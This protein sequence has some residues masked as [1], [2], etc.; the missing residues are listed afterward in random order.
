MGLFKSV[1]GF[2]EEKINLS[3]VETVTGEIDSK[4]KIK[5]L[6][7]YLATSY[8]ADTIGKCEIKRYSTYV[9][10]ILPQ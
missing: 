3:N 7:F 9:K 10:P 4:V 1:A 6:A 5:V 2:L 8:I